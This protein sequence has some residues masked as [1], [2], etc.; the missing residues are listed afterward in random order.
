MQLQ[1]YASADLFEEV[2][3]EQVIDPIP[4][5][6]INSDEN[7]LLAIDTATDPSP[8]NVVIK[9]LNEIGVQTDEIQILRWEFKSLLTSWILKYRNLYFTREFQQRNN[10]LLHNLKCLGFLRRFNFQNSRPEN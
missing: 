1:N 4:D 9:E 6:S 5:E 2:R 8:Q 3:Q 10:F 7:Q